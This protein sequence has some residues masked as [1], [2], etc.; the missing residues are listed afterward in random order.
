[1]VVRVD[2]AGNIYVGM[3]LGKAATPKAFEKDDAY[4]HCTGS[5]VK[6]GPD[7]GR[8]KCAADA[9]TADAADGVLATYPGLSP[10][11]HP[12]LGTTC[13]V[14]RVPRFGIDRFGRLAVP[15]AT[16]NYVR[17][18]DNAGNEIL[19]FGKYGNFDSR[20]VNPNTPEGKQ[21]KPTVAT[22]DIPLAWPN[23]AGFGEQSVY[24][25]DVY[26]RRVVRAD[27]TYAAEESAQIK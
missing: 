15:N 18:V 13:C 23:C 24:V 2:L 7:G 5:V 19:S 17:L 14:C 11:S 8:V 6:F 20:Y 27:L 1:M 12:H 26:N 10:F 25:L 21:G 22:P 4:K 3:I 9:M 16:G